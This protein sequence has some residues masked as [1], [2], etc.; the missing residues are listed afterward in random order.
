MA[1]V[2]DLCATDKRLYAKTARK[3]DSLALRHHTQARQGSN[4]AALR[5]AL[6]AAEREIDAASDFVGGAFDD[7][8]EPA[9]DFPTLM[10]WRLSMANQRLD[11]ANEKMVK[12]ERLAGMSEAALPSTLRAGDKVRLADASVWT[13]AAPPSSGRA[14]GAPVSL[15]LRSE[16]MG[17]TKSIVVDGREP[18]DRLMPTPAGVDAPDPE[19]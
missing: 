3:F 16:M 7:M 10:A 11:A 19:R 1:V 2:D 13:V 12:A 5:S 18:I 8:Y 14:S 4:D 6:A 15:T 9:D 17:V